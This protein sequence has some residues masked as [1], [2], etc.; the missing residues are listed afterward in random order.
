MLSQQFF[1]NHD[2]LFNA[3]NTNSLNDTSTDNGSNATV[4]HPNDSGAP[5]TE[6]SVDPTMHSEYTNATT[7][8]N[9]NPSFSADND[10]I[11]TL[12]AQVNDSLEHELKETKKAVKRIFKE[13]VAFHK[14]S[15]AVLEIWAPIHNAEHQESL[16]LDELQAEVH[17][18]IGAYSSPMG[19]YTNTIDSTDPLVAPK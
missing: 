18:T 14:V 7:E 12:M 13:I 3:E 11:A 4:F 8:D 10:E 19:S 1:N 17:G 2:G 6:I 16:R 5:W 9:G 15:K